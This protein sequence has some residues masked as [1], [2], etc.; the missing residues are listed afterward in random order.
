MTLVKEFDQNAFIVS[1]KVNSLSGR[2][3]IAP[4]K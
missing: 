1:T 3:Y 2:F 4:H